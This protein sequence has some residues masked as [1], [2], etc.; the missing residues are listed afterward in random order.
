MGVEPMSR[1]E[2]R[3]V[4]V[5]GA[6]SGI[7]A[8][9][10]RELAARGDTVAL[11]ARRQERLDEVLADCRRTSPESERWAADLSEPTAAAELTLAISDHYG[12]LDV[13]INNA[14]VPMRR[15]ATR[16]TLIEVERTMRINYL[17]P[18]AITLAILPQ[19]LE[20]GSGTIVNVSS[21]GGRLG[22]ATEA[23]YSGSKFALAGWSESLAIDLDGSGVAVKL[24]LPGAID[25]EIWDQPDND[26]P[27]YE[28]PKEPPETIAGAIVDAIDSPRF[29][30]YL[31]DMKA[32]IEFKTTDIDAFIDSMRAMTQ[33]AA[34]GGGEGGGSQ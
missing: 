23:A 8:A 15:H 24:I 28:G 32:V 5:T 26:A 13:I 11:V 17:S 7:G 31:P 30:H 6:S 4:L 33:Q 27:I 10:A 20:R 1:A 19:M 21:L 2:G 29:E 16:L 18:I 3:T 14:A 9:V 22:I 12:A 25:T 34:P